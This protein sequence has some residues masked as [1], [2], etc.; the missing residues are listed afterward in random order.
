[1]PYRKRTRQ[2]AK[3]AAARAAMERQRLQGPAPDYPLQMPDL[4]R[5]VIIIDHDFGTVE[6]RLDL[7]RTNRIDCYRVVADGVEWKKRAGWST[8]LEAVRKS[9]LR[10]G[11]R[12]D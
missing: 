10:V 11:A 6:H 9:F 8:V 7:Y 12:V 5:T 3:M 1:M 4:R 2:S